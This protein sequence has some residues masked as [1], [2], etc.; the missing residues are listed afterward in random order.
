MSGEFDGR[1]IAVT[2]AGSGIG[3]ATARLLVARG[4]QVAAMD[5][6]AESVELL[7]KELPGVAVLPVDVSDAEAVN[8]AVASAVEALGRLD[9]LAH[10][11]GVDA[12]LSIKQRVREYR[13]R[14][15]DA[16]RV[17]FDGVVELSDDEWRRMMSVNLDGTFYCVRAALRQMIPHRR[18]S[19]VL[20][21]SMAGMSGALGISHYSASKAA[22][23][24][25]G[26]SVA[27][28]VAGYGIRV[29]VVAPGPTDTAML[30]R[31]PA[32]SLAA[33][34]A[35]PLGRSARP[36]ELAELICFLLSDAASF[37]T[38]ETVNANGGMLIV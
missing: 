20:V 10:A 21:G 17:G 22:V 4:A 16:E 23:R 6:D 14:P 2:G 7:A 12:H 3:A 15:Q 8:V 37:I 35:I 38:G 33:A 27:R 11:A 9:G 19:I 13:T 29:N 1:T 30:R 24:V 28:E 25:F 31:T 36:D 32:A 5:Y 34:G 18:G 26:Q